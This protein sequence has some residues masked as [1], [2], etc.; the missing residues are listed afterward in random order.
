M[1]NRCHPNRLRAH[2]APLHAA[3]SNTPIHSRPSR[4]DSYGSRK[5]DGGPEEPESPSPTLD[6]TRPTIQQLPGRTSLIGVLMVLQRDHYGQVKHARTRMEEAELQAL[7]EDLEETGALQPPA[8]WLPVVQMH[9][10]DHPV[11]MLQLYAHYGTPHEWADEILAINGL[12]V[13][14]AAMNNVDDVSVQIPAM[15]TITLLIE[16]TPAASSQFMGQMRDF[17]FVDGTRDP[18][19]TTPSVRVRAARQHGADAVSH[20]HPMHHHIHLQATAEKVDA[21]GGEEAVRGLKE[22]DPFRTGQTAAEIE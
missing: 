17:V 5:S 12:Q 20:A 1:P 13:C 8:H 9:E 2:A 22:K 6:L 3:T 11:T 19:Q 14:L 16:L 10:D 15:S 4:N 18:I 7:E 21:I